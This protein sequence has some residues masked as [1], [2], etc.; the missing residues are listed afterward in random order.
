MGVL[1]LRSFF[2]GGFECST[3]RLH[4]GKRLDL[5]A[6][7]R[8]SELYEEDYR[9]LLAQGICSARSGIRWHLIE[10]SPYRYDF[11]SVLPMVQAAKRTGMQVIWDL[12]H[13]GWPDG[14]DIFQ[15]QF[16]D[17]FAA[18]AAA[19]ARL[20]ASESDDAPLLTPINEISYFSWAAGEV[21]Y[22]NPFAH[23]RGLELKAQ[24]VRAAIA[25]ME[26]VWEA[27][28]DAQFIHAEP[29]IRVVEHPNRPQDR[30]AAEAYT[31]SQYQAWN[32]L[33]G[34][35][36]PQ[37][38]GA[39]KY[40][41]R[42]GLNFYPTNQWILHGRKLRWTDPL[43]HPLRE[44][45]IDMYAHYQR[46]ILITETGTEGKDRSHWLRYVTG[47]VEAAVREGV[48]V[49]GICL[50]PI[51]NHPGWDNDRHCPNGLWDY[52]DDQGDRKIYRPLADEL[53]HQQARFRTPQPTQPELVCV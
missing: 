12:F 42:L 48:P 52:A 3:H 34:R 23:G 11:S 30:Y 25:G 4:T 49:E 8:H 37:L 21:G 22:M 27:V 44:L 41:S 5:L 28:P 13:Y 17:R 53:K 18:L 9:R 38:G 45:L 24:L 15:P 31:N 7:T 29:L 26:A 35:E 43:Y 46:P 20:A 50:Y 36:W 40:V 10:T 32:M 47:E 16:V 39:E 6:S 51:L 14:L 33:L 2:L 1:Q 19:F